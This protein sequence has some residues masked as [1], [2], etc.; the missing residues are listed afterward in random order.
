MS[1]L[2]CGGEIDTNYFLTDTTEVSGQANFYEL[3]EFYFLTDTNLHEL[4]EF[5]FMNFT[6]GKS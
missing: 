2:K 4:H 3:H 5:Y 6:E 1:R